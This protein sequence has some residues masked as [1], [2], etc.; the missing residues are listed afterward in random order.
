VSQ[1][2]SNQSFDELASGLASGTLSRGK[3]LRLMAAALLGGALSFTPK[4]AEALPQAIHNPHK[5]NSAGGCTEGSCCGGTC[6]GE[7]QEGNPPVPFVTCVTAASGCP[8]RVGTG[9]YHTIEAPLQPT[10]LANCGGG[11]ACTASAQCPSG[12]VCAQ[13]EGTSSGYHCFS[14]CREGGGSR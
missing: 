4:V 13:Q 5:C 9:C 11:I 3:A 8:I 2:T 14:L 10:C 6:C 12:M 1:Q 7:G